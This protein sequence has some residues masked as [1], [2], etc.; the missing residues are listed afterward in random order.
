MS[1]ETR[2]IETTTLRFTLDAERAARATLR[3]SHEALDLELGRARA[4][5]EEMGNEKLTRL[6]QANASLYAALTQ[7]QLSF[8]QL[9]HE[10]RDVHLFFTIERG[11]WLGLLE[12]MARHVASRNTGEPVEGLQA[13]LGML[14]KSFGLVERSGGRI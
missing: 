2:T 13:A 11:V 9:F 8:E 3:L 14:L 7:D 5:A 6:C 12:H 10:I 1:I 4:D